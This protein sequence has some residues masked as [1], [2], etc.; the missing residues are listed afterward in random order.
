V[1]AVVGTVVESAGA[2]RKTM[3][4][5]DKFAGVGDEISGLDVGVDFL[6]FV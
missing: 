4:V 1:G 3:R 6:G 5:C 2:T